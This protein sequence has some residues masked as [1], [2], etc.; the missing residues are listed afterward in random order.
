MKIVK[1]V[2]LGINIVFIVVALGIFLLLWMSDDTLYFDG[3]RGYVNEN[4]ELIWENGEFASGYTG[5]YTFLYR[6]YVKLVLKTLHVEKTD[7]AVRDLQ[8]AKFSFYF[9]DMQT[10]E[11][12]L[13]YDFYQDRVYALI[14]GQWYRVRETWLLTDVITRELDRSLGSISATWRGQSTLA[15]EEYYNTD[16]SNPTFRYNLYWTPSHRPNNSYDWLNYRDSGFSNVTPVSIQS[17][18]EAIQQAA[19]ELGYQNPIGVA[20]YDETCGYWLVEILEDIGYEG[21]SSAEIQKPIMDEIYTVIMDN[22][23]RTLEIYQSVTKYT[24]FI[25]AIRDK[26]D[27]S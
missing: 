12:L 11:L 20:M 2:L 18:A 6:G 7:D 15:F 21:D 3:G 27:L 23:G 14:E 24:P 19:K 4:G 22:Q 10:Y 17:S 8:L 25:E 1:R 26:T 5:N 13:G 16:M 9:Y